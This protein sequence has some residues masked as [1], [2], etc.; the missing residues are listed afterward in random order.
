MYKLEQSNLLNEF[1]MD[2]NMNLSRRTFIASAA[3]APVAC[4]SLSYEHGIPVA[5]PKPLP[6]V[7]PPQ[8]GQEWTY[9]KKDIFDGKTLDVITERVSNVGSNIVIDRMTADSLT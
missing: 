4:G 5:Q 9:I 7:R 8:V 2:S 1:T 6:A 3:L